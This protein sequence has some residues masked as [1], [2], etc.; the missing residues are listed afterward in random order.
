MYKMTNR[1]ITV[2]LIGLLGWGCSSEPE[3]KTTY[4]TGQFSVADSMDQSNDFSGIGLT[5]TK[6]DSANADADT[7]FH[8]VTDSSGTFSGAVSFDESRQYSATLSRGGRNL[9]RVG[10]ILADGDTINIS[11]TLPNLRESL[12][13]SSTEH[14][15]MKVYERIS[16]NFERIRK[17]ANAGVL[18][19]DSLQ[20]EIV[21]W[22]D[23]FWQVHSDNKGAIAAELAARDAIRI[24][25]GFDNQKMMNRLRSVQ[26]QDKF[27]DL[28][29]TVG[30]NHIA[31]SQGLEP[32]LSYL[33][34]LKQVTAD[35]SK[36]MRISMERIKL[37]YD[38]ARVDAAKQELQAFKEEFNPKIQPAEWVES[39]SYDLN[40]MSPG[41][42]IPEFSFTENGQT[43]SRDSLLGTPFIL[44]VTRLS[45][46]LYQNQ[47]DRTVAIH[48]IYKNYG[49]E[50]VTLPLDESQITV[51]AFFDE[52]PKPWPVADAQTFDRNQ[53]LE[54]F[55]VRLIPTRFLIDREGKI[56]RKYVGQEYQDVIDGIQILIQKEKKPAS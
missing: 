34:T 38:S 52:R 53:L 40:Y 47:F 19:G 32:T 12:T 50:V 4:I 14:D 45:N 37:L 48:S 55:N 29:A 26:E 33:D 54:K 10:L 30:K 31:Q 23:M 56:I 17:Y 13:I 9:G 36:R 6:K 51:D 2:M 11:A 7:L 43:I 18:K 1:L 35:S 22:S 27:S 41:D 39:M 42:T 25:Q 46:R 8:R 44:E 49:L 5:L 21:K 3:T 20:Q 16:K 15:A 24:L 28:G